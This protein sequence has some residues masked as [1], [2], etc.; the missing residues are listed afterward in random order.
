MPKKMIMYSILNTHLINFYCRLTNIPPCIVY[1]HSILLTLKGWYS[2]WGLLVL[3]R[4]NNNRE[5]F[6]VSSPIKIQS[7]PRWGLENRSHWMNTVVHCNSLPEAKQFITILGSI[8]PLSDDPCYL[9]A[10]WCSLLLLSYPCDHSAVQCLVD[11]TKKCTLIAVTS[12]V[13]FGRQNK[14]YTKKHTVFLCLS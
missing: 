4:V 13:W 2:K 10:V 14:I 7:T 6:E 1:V 11:N 3:N 12:N 8:P 9:S 5:I